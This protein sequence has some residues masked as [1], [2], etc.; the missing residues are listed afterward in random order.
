MNVVKV[1]LRLKKIKDDPLGFISDRI[2]AFIVNL[3]IP[4]PLAGEIVVLFKRPI[5]GLLVTFII[6]A[7]FMTTVI[8]TIFMSPLLLTSGFLKTFISAFQPNPSDIPP[9]T[10]FADTGV[11]GRNPFGGV[12]M[13][14]STVT[15]YFL[16]PSY[17]L[18]FGRN[19]T[20]VDMV[21]TSEYYKNSQT[22]EQ[23]RKVVAFAT[24]SGSVNHYIDGYGGETVEIT[25]AENTFRVLYV[26]FSLTLV[27]SG[28]S[29]KAGSPVGIM[30]DT[31]F[32]TGNHV[33]YEIH[34]KDGD[35]W[36]AV[37]PLNYI[38]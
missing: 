34:I 13:G 36:R 38:Q 35:G 7:L 30:G 11:P 20:G 29:V 31:G 18:Q 16:D 5:M 10:S 4:I 24:I 28:A 9:D 8:G 2:V 23:T 17:Y 19:H 32:S 15:A 25:N 6:F 27:D 3:L 33:H 22:Y 37:N 1:P 21:P 26:H 12:G 14:Y